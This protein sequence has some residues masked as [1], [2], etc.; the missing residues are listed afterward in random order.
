MM[1][2]PVR[3]K[4]IGKSIDPLGPERNLNF[5]RTRVTFVNT[6]AADDFLFLRLLKRHSGGA[7]LAGT[8]NARRNWRA[9]SP[10]PL[11]IARLT[12]QRARPPNGDRTRFADT[13]PCGI[14][15]TM[16]RLRHMAN[17]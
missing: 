8:Y 15:R 11:S 1:I 9:N 14:H 17:M 3:A 4:V 5:R 13:I 6:E 10:R 7:S 16:E 12:R 2:V